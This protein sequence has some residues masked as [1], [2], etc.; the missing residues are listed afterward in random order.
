MKWKII[1]SLEM[2]KRIL[3][4]GKFYNGIIFIN[5]IQH[6]TYGDSHCCIVTINLK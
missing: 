4:D 3:K 1:S 2:P 6:F 5:K